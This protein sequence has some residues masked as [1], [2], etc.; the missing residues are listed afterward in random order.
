MLINISSDLNDNEPIISTIYSIDDDDRGE[1]SYDNIFFKAIHIKEEIGAFIYFKKLYYEYPTVEFK[2]RDQLSLSN[3]ITEVDLNEQSYTFNTK[4]YLNDFIKMNNDQICYI[5]TDNEKIMLYIVI[6]TLY[7]SDN[8][9]KVSIKYYEHN[10]YGSFGIN[11]HEQI[12]SNI[13]NNMITIAFSHCLSSRPDYGSSFFIIGY[14][15][16]YSYS[17]DVI[18]E[19]KTQNVTIDQLC[20]NLEKT[21]TI[22]N[23]LF[24]YEFY[25]TEIID[26]PDE[27]QLLLGDTVIPKHFIIMNGR[28]LNISFPNQQ[29]LYKTNSYKIEIAYVVYE[30]AYTYLGSYVPKL[31][32]GKYTN[33]TFTIKNDIYCFDNNCILCEDT[34]QCLICNGDIN[35]KQFEEKCLNKEDEIKTD[36]KTDLNTNLKTEKNNEKYITTNSIISQNIIQQSTNNDIDSTN[37]FI[38]Q[39]ESFMINITESIIKENNCSLDDLIT[40]KCPSVIVN[41]QI[42]DIYNKLLGQI[43]SNRSLT[44]STEKVIF[45]IS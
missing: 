20:F 2:I 44:I 10:I 25:G 17:F 15:S 7:S 36:L 16:S 11:F 5:S 38:F 21:L 13:Y 24:A 43:K 19:I 32:T 9:N 45:Q 31:F 6:L 39:N 42:T 18:N 27:L 4:V 40:N 3:Y 12:I 28:C 22:E 41:E 26:F 35:F 37:N 23:N 14:P 34:L 29:G 8:E 33:F 30:T 1:E